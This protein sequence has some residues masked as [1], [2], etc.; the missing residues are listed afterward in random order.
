MKQ[1]VSLLLVTVATGV[2][3]APN[4]EP[5]ST[6]T[7]APSSIELHDQ[8]DAPQTLSFPATNVTLLTIADK[9]G[10]EQ[11]AGWVAPLK[12]RFGKRID[13]RGLAD[14][15]AVPRLLRGMVRK[16]FQRLQTYPVMLDWSGAAVKAFTYV[17]DKANV[18][19]LDGHGQILKRISGEANPKAVQDLCAA[20][21]RALINRADKL[22]A[23]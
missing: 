11:V 15:S 22:S 1:L 13:I 4:S 23:Q 10:S 6:P 12:Q 8:F 20:I 18:L 7:N 2:C 14:V 17:P 9:K 21:D 16:K 5:P 19:V 3:A